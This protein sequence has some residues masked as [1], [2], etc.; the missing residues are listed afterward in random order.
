MLVKLKKILAMPSPIYS[1]N[2]PVGF[3][4]EGELDGLIEFDRTI[5]IKENKQFF[6]LT[7][8]GLIQEIT[9][10]NTFNTRGSKWRWEEIPWEPPVVVVKE[11][12]KKVFESGL[13][14]Q[15]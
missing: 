12:P 8:I 11:E 6:S 15:E 4:I 5:Y 10:P 7:K 13:I 3:E 1:D 9:S 14:I 2:Y